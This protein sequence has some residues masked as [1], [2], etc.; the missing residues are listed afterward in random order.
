MLIIVPTIQLVEQFY[1]DFSDY[2]L[3]QHVRPC[4]FCGALERSLDKDAN[5][6]IAN[7]QWLERHSDDLPHID[8]VLIDEVHGLKSGSKLSNYVQSM[9]CAIKLGMTGTMPDGKDD[10]WNI[11][12]VVGPLLQ[13]RNI[14]E[15]Q[16]AGHIAAIRILPVKIE[17]SRK[18][19]WPADSLE[20]RAKAFHRE[21]KH[22]EAV[23]ESN[24][25]VAALA[26]GLRGNTIVLFDHTD[27]GRELFRLMPSKDKH[28]VNG[29]TDINERE[30]VRELM[31][32]TSGVVGVMNVKACGTGLNVKN[33]DN[34][35][36]AM[37]GKGT[38][39]IIQSIGRGLRTRSTDT[40]TLLLVDIHH[41]FRYSKKH[42]EAR[43]KLYEDNYRVTLTAADTKTLSV[44]GSEG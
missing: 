18:P 17:H 29:D 3:D 10:E 20:D 32:A 33:V 35:V 16:D 22:I 12:G 41:G 1:K 26:A 40:K 6:I 43:K 19:H 9:S 11:L 44:T 38:T 30:R 8:A 36:L 2:G 37:F 31:E 34:I 14:H 42:F 15:M 39:K 4:K 24:A 21:W 7:R 13:S 23:K 27:H 5:V 28:F 25:K